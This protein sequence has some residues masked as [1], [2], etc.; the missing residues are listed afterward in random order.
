MHYL[1]ALMSGGER[2]RVAIARALANRPS[3]ILADELTGMLDSRTTQDIL[4]LLTQLNAQQGTTMIIVTHNHEVA[5]AT[6]RVIT[7]RDGKVQSD[8][9]IRSA[10]ESDLLDWKSSTLGQAIL[11]GDGVP[12]ELKAIV[13]QLREAFDKV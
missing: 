11:Q 10:Y 7:F 9:A 2:Q 3:I 6:R 5:R 8:V 13:P 1:P 4:A 12:D